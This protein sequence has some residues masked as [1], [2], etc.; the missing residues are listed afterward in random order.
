MS[1][2]DI[3]KKS[4]LSKRENQKLL[5]IPFFVLSIKLLIL[6]NIANNAWIGAD[7][8]NYIGG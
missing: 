7:G 1:K 8:E 4:G 2:K 3:S 5:A 6:T